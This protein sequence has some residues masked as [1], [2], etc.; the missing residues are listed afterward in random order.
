ML[1]MD[2]LSRVQP[3]QGWY[4]ILGIKDASVK[5][6][7]VETREEVDQTTEAYVEAGRNVFFGVAKYATDEGRKKDNVQALR[8]FWLDIDCGPSKAEVDPKTG[9]A[10][11]Y[12]D[13]QAG[14]QALQ[15]F[16][17]TV[18]L[19]RPILVDSGRG[20]HVYWPLDRDVSRTEWEP[21]AA[22]L[23]ELCVS[24][25]FFVDP[26][27]FE[28]SR[29]L[30]IPGTYN[31][32]DDPPKLVSVIA[33]APDVNFDTLKEIL[34]VKEAEE[35]KAP[36]MRRELSALGKKFQ[37]NIQYKFSRIMQRSAAGKGC[38]QLADSFLN[39]A[40]LSELRWFDALSVAKFCSDRD[41]AIHKLSSGHP[42]YDP[43]ATETKIK[44]IVG[45]H[46]CETF[47]KN[48][49]G[50][51]E[52]CPFKGKIKNPILL[53]RDILE[54]A[55]DT[56]VAEVI[57]PETGEME[58]VT[59]PK[60]PEPYF[61]GANGGIYRHIDDPEVTP[62]LVYAND[63]YIVKRM[64]D[65]RNGESAILRVHLPHNEVRT[66]A[67]TMSELHDAN[68]CRA[69]LSK[70]GVVC[71]GP[72]RFALLSEYLYTALDEIQFA[73]KPEHMR[74]QFGWADK[75]TKFILGDRE[76]TPEGTFHS[77]PSSITTHLAELIQPMGSYELWQEAF[78]LYGRPGLEPNA[79]AALTA[80][81]S[82]LFR[83]T[84]HSGALINLVNSQS[85]T[86][87]TTV[88]HMINSVYG[89][90][91]RLCLTK[92]D[93]YNAKIQK[94]GV[95]NNLCPTIDE[96][97]NM[98]A[99]EFSELIYSISQGRGKDRM[100]GSD[101]ELRHNATTWQCIA[102]S[103]SNASFYEKMM[104]KKGTPDGEM[105]RLIEY[106]ISPHDAVDMEL[107]K[108]M[109]DSQLVENYGHAG[110]IYL[111][112][113]VKNLPE[114]IDT[115]RATQQKIDAELRLTQ[116]E[117]FWSA[118]LAANMTGGRI[119]KRLGLIDW[120]LRNIYLWAASMLNEMRQDVIP[121]LA[122]A[123]AVVGSY[124]NRNLNNMLVVNS[125]AD[126]RSGANT[127]VLPQQ[128]PKGELLIRYEPDTKELFLVVG[129][130][131]NDCAEVQIAYKETVAELKKKGILK[132]T[133]NE[134]VSKG[135]KLSTPSVHCLV[136]DAS[137][138]EFIDMNN[139]IS[140]E[141]TTDAGGGG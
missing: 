141:E 11:G 65:P 92:S 81:G 125:A 127:K 128:E 57:Q 111:S 93:T 59:I 83:F 10:A 136:L 6:Q 45:P 21:V 13:Q 25:E 46:N 139:L 88:L 40:E 67:A 48:N 31:F 121:P 2:L 101:N 90:P 44:H 4:A 35:A 42:D 110:V 134:R 74:L 53:G 94:V 75:D 16:C 22:R 26:A 76:I 66:F 96:I 70:H 3:S 68:K 99:R 104:S 114:V 86:G 30:R 23:G 105:M 135:M 62:P 32:K 102:V 117:R 91:K 28:V 64:I 107:G 29:V 120:D 122:D 95:L 79:F 8:A 24:Q 108:K 140:K 60:Y 130:F 36:P 69:T 41:V 132:R 84:G 78:N 123:M 43:G 109:F 106:K 100:T 49:P 113:V 51:C 12:I 118:V 14:L 73:R 131:R 15:K 82:P 37:D 56:H 97:T 17:K 1:D 71:G 98:I 20:I 61:R 103:S 112:W 34:G 50:G 77:P 133:S 52:G 33:D 85:G 18:G 47:E 9:R 116:R 89:D 129:P 124:L 38:Q 39:R 72:K 126:R 115:L 27:V 54:D 58:L 7:L 5:Q 119:A 138:P 19:P 55:A 137:H 80:F 63:L 87:K